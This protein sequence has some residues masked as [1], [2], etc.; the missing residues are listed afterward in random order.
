MKL[1]LEFRSDFT[2]I[3]AENKVYHLYINDAAPNLT[4]EVVKKAMEDI[5]A[6]KLFERDA[7]NAYGI[8]VRAR[9]ID[10]KVTIVYEA[11]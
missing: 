5:A 9:Y 4:K 6:A 8:P 2:G 7:L 11:A 10:R 3:G 1:D